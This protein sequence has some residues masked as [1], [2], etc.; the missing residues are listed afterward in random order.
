MCATN[1]QWLSWCEH[2]ESALNMPSGT[3]PCIL[4]REAKDVRAD[5]DISMDKPTLDEV[6]SAIP[7]LKN[8]CAPVRMAFHQNS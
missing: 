8:G 1:S 2:F 5:P 4:D 7:K 3:S 6:K